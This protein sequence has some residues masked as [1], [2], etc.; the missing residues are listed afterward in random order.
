MNKK[1]IYLFKSISMLIISQLFVFIMIGIFP[2][3]QK[4]LLT[5]NFMFIFIYIGIIVNVI[6][7]QGES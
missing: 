2:N 4:I 1:H 7:F 3:L 5:F 6:I